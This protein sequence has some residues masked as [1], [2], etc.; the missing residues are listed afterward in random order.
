M[1]VTSHCHYFAR[2]FLF[3]RAAQHENAAAAPFG[4]VAGQF[5]EIRRRPV[6]RRAE[7]RAGIEANHLGI[8]GQSRRVPDARRCG[9]VVRSRTQIHAPARGRTADVFGE[10]VVGVEDRTRQRPAIAAAYRFQGVCQQRRAPVSSVA[11]ATLA[12][13]EP[14]RERGTKRI[15][16]ENREIDAPLPQCPRRRPNALHQDQFIEPIAAREETGDIRFGHANDARIG[17]V[18]PQRAQG[19]RRHHGVA[20]PTGK[21]HGHVHDK[22]TSRRAEHL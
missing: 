17:E 3:R 6:F 10:L 22:K 2:H 12:P 21:H 19:R 4:Q 1:R 11:D 13:A 7:R 15:W 5:G 9:F 18:R 14:D 16:K 20:D 8:R